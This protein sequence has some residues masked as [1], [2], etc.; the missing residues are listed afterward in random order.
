MFGAFGFGYCLMFLFS[1]WKVVSLVINKALR[2]RIYA[3]TLAVL[4]SLPLQILLLGLSALW[5]PDQPAFGGVSLALFLS[6]FSCAVVGEG[7][8]VI[9]PI[10]ES[11]AVGGDFSLWNPWRR[12]AVV[13]E[14]RA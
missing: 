12:A 3:L 2:F 13:G 9:K 6:T 1:S 10:T 4:I 8:L 7:I 5:Q 14:G 11:L